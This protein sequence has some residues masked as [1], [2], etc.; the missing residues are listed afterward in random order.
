MLTRLFL[1]LMAR[2]VA[3]THG[4]EVY[5]GEHAVLERLRRKKP[6]A[7]W[8]ELYESASRLFADTDHLYLDKKQALLMLLRAAGE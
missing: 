8:L 6:V 1:W 4:Q 7:G 3:K 5:H 2:I